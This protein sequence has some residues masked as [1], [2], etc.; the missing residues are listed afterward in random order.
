MEELLFYGDI[1]SDYQKLLQEYKKLKEERDKYKLRVEQLE[2]C[3]INILDFNC[4][5][6]DRVLRLINQI[7]DKK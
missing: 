3:L 7:G 5:V 2:S 1:M 4:M 6:K